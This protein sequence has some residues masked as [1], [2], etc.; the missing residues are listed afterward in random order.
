MIKVVM[1]HYVREYSDKRKKLNFLHIDDFI[2][3]LD[4]FES[5][6]GILTKEDW[7]R[8]LNG[9]MVSGYLLTFDDGLIDH[10]NYVYPELIRRGK[11][12]IFYVSTM[13]ILN[14]TPC[15]VHLCHAI[16]AT[17][18]AKEVYE[19]LQEFLSIY[20]ISHDNFSKEVLYKTQDNSNYEYLVKKL[21]N[22]QFSGSRKL[23]LIDF[24]LKEFDIEI[25]EFIDQTYMG[26]DEIRE[27]CAAGMIVGSHF[28]SHNL[29]GNLPDREQEIE[30]NL[31]DTYLKKLIGTDNISHCF[32]YGGIGSYNDFT[33]KLLDIE[34]SLYSFAVR[35][36]PLPNILNSDNRYTLPRYDCNEFIYGERYE[37]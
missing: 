14:R 2:K 37:Y 32:P 4:F 9:E 34:N 29:L 19:K 33:V 1:Y 30:L 6:M 22:Y 10:Y 13:P 15:S 16:L 18:D 28:H 24:L 31:S 7:D 35:S 8:Y 11:L 17:Y 23:K 26:E 27:I 25:D 3:Q 20:P 5:D 21:I 36:E 12:G